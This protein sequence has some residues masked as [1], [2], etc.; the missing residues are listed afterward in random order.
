MPIWSTEI[1]SVFVPDYL[2]GKPFKGSTNISSYG[3]TPSPPDPRTTEDCLFLDVLTPKKVFKHRKKAPVIVWIYGGAY[4]AGDKTA[5]DVT[6][7]V[8][9]SMEDGGKGI[10]LVAINYR[11][12]AF[13]W[14]PGTDVKAHG[15]VNAGLYDQRFALQWVKEHIHRFGGDPKKV[16]IMGE[17]A[18]AGSIMHQITAYGGVKG[19]APFQRAILQSPGFFPMPYQD[20]QDAV[21]RDFLQLL[22]VNTI[23]DARR[24]PSE[25]L[26]SANAYQVAT[27]PPYGTFVYGPVVDGI[28][29]PSLP[30]ALLWGGAFDRTVEVM[31][32][33]NA[34]EGLEFTSPNTTTEAGIINALK[35]AF[36]DMTP[37]VVRHVVTDLYPPI[38][39][40]RYGYTDS[41]GQASLI[42]SDAAFQCNT[43]YLNRAF[44]NRT[45]AYMFS[46]PPAL[47]AQD[48]P[49]TF[50]NG[51]PSLSVRNSTVALVL[52]DYI[53][54]FVK[55]GK[56]RSSL[57]PMFPRHGADAML[58]NLR[59]SNITLIRDPTANRRCLWWQMA[60]Y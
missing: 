29:V 27:R 36:P 45:Y 51:H 16:T 13:G 34:N 42:T 43:D 10:V 9:R 15:V 55:S 28:F 26:I 25:K 37:S 19:P 21:L 59:E 22:G 48:M 6:G 30:G 17:S 4:V 49:Y 35:E 53:I 57:G 2:Q 33:H 52:Q 5:S 32:G 14:L 3:Y 58:V 8:R 11:V 39:D 56:P 1:A 44:D 46:I 50:F 23:D 24:L 60:P 20:Q 38:F 18:G 31:V 41:V 7:L 54:N 12:G 47:H 40:G